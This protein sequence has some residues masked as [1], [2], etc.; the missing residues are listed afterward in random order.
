MGMYKGQYSDRPIRMV[1]VDV[2][3][4]TAGSFLTY[5]AILDVNDDR[6]PARIEI[7][8]IIVNPAASTIWRHRIYRRNDTIDESSMV[9]DDNWSDFTE[10]SSDPTIDGTYWPYCSQEDGADDA[11]VGGHRITG[12]IDVM[13]GESNSAFKITILFK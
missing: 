3:S 8:R 11:D 2:A 9:Y 5:T 10:A 1:V 7:E 4:V 6:I 13:A 12:R